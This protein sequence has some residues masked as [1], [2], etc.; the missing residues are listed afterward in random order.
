V[1]IQ[2]YYNLYLHRPADP[3]GRAG[4]SSFLAAGGTTDQLRA[5]ILGSGE[6]ASTHFGGNSAPSFLEGV[7]HDVLYR[8]LDGSGSNF[9]TQA[10]NN[11]ASHTAV[12]AAIIASAEGAGNEVQDLFHR[13]LHRAPDPTGMSQFSTALE[14]GASDDVILALI[15]GSAE[16]RNLV[17]PLP[18]MQ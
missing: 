2:K 6:Y 8:T 4:W 12:A 10:L 15:A 9:W 7:Y 18:P 14:Q 17:F 16:Y 1:V 5:F 3:T 11:G 13:L